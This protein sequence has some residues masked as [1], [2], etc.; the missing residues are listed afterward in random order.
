VTVMT[1]GVAGPIDLLDLPG[2]AAAAGRR[3]QFY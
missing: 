2:F 1:V 3:R